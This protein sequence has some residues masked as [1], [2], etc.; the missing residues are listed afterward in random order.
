MKLQTEILNGLTCHIADGLAEGVKPR[1]VV[2]LCHGY[3]APGTD[4]VGL[5]QML[6]R[7]PRMSAA[8]QFLF[9]EAPLSLEAL[10]M[11]DG[12]A[13][14]PIDMRRLQMAVALGTFHELRKDCPQELPAAREMLLGLIREWS[15][16]SGVPL[17]HFILGGFS[18]GSMLATDVTLQLDKN[19]AGLVI[20]SGTLMNEDVWRDRATHHKALRV[21]QSHG[22]TDPLLPF[23]AAGW[24]RDLLK[25]AGADVEFLPFAGGHEIPHNVLDR[26]GTFVREIVGDGRTSV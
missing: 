18:Q 13:W 15:Q 17:E 19:P 26:F 25:Q 24:I 21:L 7:Q 10:G 16:R 4:L 5:S 12:R 9:P 1:C 20:L 14:W 2:V 8:V 6:L 3:G 22:T 11:P 23:A